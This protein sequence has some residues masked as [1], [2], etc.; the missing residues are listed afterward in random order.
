MLDQ[1]I[2][3]AHRH[4]Q[5]HTVNVINL[6]AKGTIEERMLDTLAAK[7]DV[8]A[9]VFGNEEAPNE[10]TFHDSGQSL[11]QKLDEMLGAPPVEVKLDLTPKA[12]PEAQVTPAP[13]LRAFADRLVGHFPGRIMLVRRAP[14]LPG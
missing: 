11:M 10:I 3:R 7:R 9:G 13:T 12:T 2:A 8:F 14:Q 4:G 6:I 1:R 5:P